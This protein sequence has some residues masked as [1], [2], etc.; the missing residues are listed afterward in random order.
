A[1]NISLTPDINGDGKPDFLVYDVVS[2]VTTYSIAFND[3]SGNPSL[4][5]T[6]ITIPTMSAGVPIRGAKPLFADMDGDGAT[7]L[8]WGAEVPN[9]INGQYN[10]DSSY[11]ILYQKGIKNSNAGFGALAFLG[12]APWTTIPTSFGLS[13][14]TT[15]TCGKKSVLV[16]RSTP[17]GEK[18][19]YNVFLNPASTGTTMSLGLIP[20]N[21]TAGLGISIT[22][23]MAGSAA[24]NVAFSDG[25]IPLGSASIVNGL[26]TLTLRA[27]LS[28]GNHSISATYAGNA[29]SGG[30]NAIQTIA[31]GKAKTQNI[32]SVVAD[33]LD[34]GSPV[35]LTSKVT[36]FN[37]T[38]TA[39]FVDE[40]GNEIGQASLINGTAALS[41]I[42]PKGKYLI[43][44]TYLGDSSNLASSSN[45]VEIK[46]KKFKERK[47]KLLP[48]SASLATRAGDFSI[49]AKR[50][51]YSWTSSLRNFFFSGFLNK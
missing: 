24:G 26:A 49:N 38:G 39:V 7:D 37:P 32:L 47:A 2:F 44:A 18:Y 50:I 29:C 22:A 15:N 16:Q 45:Q 35:V 40:R 20:L 3:G 19:I 33:D 11:Q 9:I 10:S 17:I 46:V 5:V 51:F 34:S 21:A 28:V 41:I 14:I 13:A 30:S 23:T 43:K 8:V 4:T 12:E 36:G 27:G 1:L 6:P 25:N 42:L 31:V 48:D